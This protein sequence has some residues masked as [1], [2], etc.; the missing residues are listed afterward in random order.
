MD[1][2]RWGARKVPN[3]CAP[4]S[5]TSA[6]RANISFFFFLVNFFDTWKPGG[7][8]VLSVKPGLAK[9]KSDKESWRTEF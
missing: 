2:W 5:Q 4:L 6:R 7:L 8:L 1:L 9:W 3:F